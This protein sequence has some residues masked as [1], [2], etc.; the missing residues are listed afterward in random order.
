M[1]EK[2]AGGMKNL[3]SR[4]LYLQVYDEIKDYILQNQMKAGDKLPTEMEMCEELGVSR[5]VLREAIKSLEITGIVSS[6]PGVGIIIQEFS[7]DFLFQ[8][9][10]YNLTGDSEDLL[11]Q[12][13]AVRRTL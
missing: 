2:L 10:F 11:A 4:K 5:N 7:T 9:L 8:S 12:T 6:K 13:L 3:K 1:A